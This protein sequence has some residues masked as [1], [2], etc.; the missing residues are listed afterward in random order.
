MNELPFDR[1]HKFP[2]LPYGIFFIKG[3]HY[4]GYHIRFKDLARGG[5]RTVLTERPEFVAHERN[6]I[7][8]EC[9]NLA[10]TQQFKN[11]DIPEGGAK[12]IIFLKP[13]D[14]ISTEINILKRELELS[15]ID[16]LA[17]E[18]NLEHFKNEQKTEYLQQSQRSFIDTLLTLVNC[19]PD[20]SLKAKNIVDYYKIPEYLYLGPDENMHNE[21]IQWIADKSKSVG[22]KPGS[23]FISSKPKAGINHKEYGVTSLGLNV[24]VEELLKFSGIDPKKDPFTIKMSGG[25]DGDV[26]GNQILNFYRFYPDTAKI[27]AITDISGTIYDPKGLDKALLADFFKERK[28]IRFYPP[29]KLNDGGFMLD[30]ENR[31]QDSALSI[32]TLFYKKEN[33]KLI[34][35]WLNGSEMNYV[36][37]TSMHKTKAD[38]FI[39]GGG[40]PKTLNEHN[41]KE[42]LDESGKPTS[43]LIVEGANLYIT[44]SAREK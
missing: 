38:I 36:Y 6:Q 12:G 17:I 35:E 14:Q 27:I 25:P 43:Y 39:P 16:E 3:M 34:E 10:L 8:S 31:R 42:Y 32:Q 15:K 41:L 40:R 4:F 21:I 18:D 11:K 7:F 2:T 23:A 29:Q 5:L 22:Y 9:Y 1:T 20:G 33:G 13:D 26:A 44:P 28:P 24:Y 37:R 30:L 19:H